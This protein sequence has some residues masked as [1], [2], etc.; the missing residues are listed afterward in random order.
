[1][2][3]PL[4]CEDPAV[5]LHRI[6]FLPL[7]L[8]LALVAAGGGARAAGAASTPPPGAVSLTGAPATAPAA[9]SAEAPTAPLAAAEAGFVGAWT[10]GL[11]PQVRARLAALPPDEAAALR[12][13]LGDTLVF[14]ADH[15]LRIFPRC[16]QAA[17]FGGAAAE[18]LPARWE[19]VGGRT[20]R[21]SSERGG[22]PVDRS[23]AFRLEG[24]ELRFFETMAAKPQVMGRY[25]GPLPP[26]CP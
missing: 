13:K 1:M 15:T 22:Q 14:R 18:G 17:Q 6:P 26:R 12:A 23:T 11:T 5:R 19:V 16:A 25:D 24:D 8:V 20:L 2:S 10:D 9:S 3:F 4:A 21:V 7:A